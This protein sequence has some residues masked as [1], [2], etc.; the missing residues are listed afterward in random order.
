MD[1]LMPVWQL[2][3]VA[4]ASSAACSFLVWAVSLA[5][6]PGFVAC[7]PDDVLS[8]V[9]AMMQERGLV[10]VLLID[11]NNKLLGVVNAREGLRALLAAGN[12]EEALLRNGSV[13]IAG[14]GGGRTGQAIAVQNA[15]L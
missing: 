11:P 9:L 10:H 8:D 13:A 12:Q 6:T 2:A 15:R 5:R 1:P 3:V 4:L 7:A 14:S